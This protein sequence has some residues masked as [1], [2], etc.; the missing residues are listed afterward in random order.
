M[1]PEAGASTSPSAQEHVEPEHPPLPSEPTTAPSPKEEHVEP[2]EPKPEP[3]LTGFEVECP[4][5]HKKL[6]I[7]HVQ[8]PSGKVFHE[9]EG[10]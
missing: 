8:Y 10:E 3:L 7:N 6:L 9:V 5:C 2:P 1:Q 4:E